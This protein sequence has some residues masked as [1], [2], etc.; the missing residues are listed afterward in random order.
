LNTFTSKLT[1]LK[2]FFDDLEKLKIHADNSK[3]MKDGNL[4]AI[5][6]DFRKWGDKEF[7]EK[8]FDQIEDTITTMYEMNIGRGGDAS[9]SKVTIMAHSMGNQ[10]THLFLAKM[11]VAWK[12]KYI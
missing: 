9:N 10:I 3:L 5:A 12:Q 1:F 7:S 11:S 2:T 6:Y 8:L 4:R